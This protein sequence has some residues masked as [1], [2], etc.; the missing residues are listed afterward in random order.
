MTLK[1][2]EIID[3]KFW[4]LESEGNKVAT[5]AYSDEKYMVTDA[6]GTR[7]V[8]DKRALEK[9]LGTVNWSALNYRSHTRRSSRL[10][11]KLQTA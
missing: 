10:S 2:K 5:L 6:N 8:D 11:Y 9:D 7:F 1:A 3:G 4:I